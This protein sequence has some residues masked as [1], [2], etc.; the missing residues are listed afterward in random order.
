LACHDLLA[1]IIISIT[2]FVSLHI[3][4]ALLLPQRADVN[5][6]LRNVMKRLMMVNNLSPASPLAPGPSGAAT[7]LNPN[8]VGSAD[9]TGACD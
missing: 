2:I 3:L 9:N 8:Q 1:C 6:Q 5:R 4:F 7:P